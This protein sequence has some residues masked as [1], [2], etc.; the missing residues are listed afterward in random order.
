MK[1]MLINATQPE[2][3]RVAMVDGQFL[4]DL[5]IEVAGRSQRK[6]SIYKAKITRVEQSLEAAFVDYGAERHGFLPFKE[7]AHEYYAD[8]KTEVGEPASVKDVLAEGLELLVQVEKEERGRKGAA[9]TTFPSLAGRYL[10]LMP[11]NPRAGGISRRI[12]GEDRAELRE[13]L[14]VLEVPAGMGLIVRTAGVGKSPEELQWDLDYLLKLWRAI[15]TAVD[16]RTGPFLVYQESNVIIRAIRD[17]FSKDVSE[18]LIDD[19]DVYRQAQDFITQVMPESAGRLRRYEGRVPLFSRFQI[20]SQIESAFSHTVRL[21]SGGSIVIDHTEALV[22][23]DVNSARATKGSDIEE[24]ALNTNL[25]AADEVARQLRLR[26][27]GGLIVI[28][29]IDMTPTRNQREVEN[30]LREALKQDRARIQ[31]RRISRFGLLEMSRQRL[32]PSLGDSSLRTC[33]TCNGRGYVRDPESLALSILRIVEEE[34]M[35]DKTGRI[36]A[37][38]P[39]EV[40]TFLLNEKREGVLDIEKRNGAQIFLVPDP[41]VTLPNYEVERVREE[42]QRNESAREA[43][44]ELTAEVESTPAFATERA[45]PKDEPAVKAAPPPAPAPAPAP[46]PVTSSQPSTETPDKTGL[47]ARIWKK[48]FGNGRKSTPTPTPTPAPAKPRPTSKGS[49][50][51]DVRRDSTRRGRGDGADPRRRGGGP[52]RGENRPGHGPNHG[53]GR[54]QRSERAAPP[55]PAAETTPS[56]PSTP[57]EPSAPV[58]EAPAAAGGEGRSRSGRRGSRRGRR[59]GSRNRGRDSARAAAGGVDATQTPRT[60]TQDGASD[61]GERAETELPATSTGNRTGDA[62]DRAETERPAASTSRTSGDTGERA[63]TERPAAS[64][65]RTSGDTGERAETERPAAS[66]SRT[67]GDTGER[68]ETERPPASAS[69]TSGDTGERA[70]T[71]RPAASASRTSGDTGERAETERPAASASRTSGDTGEHAETERPAASAGRTSGDTGERAET[72]RPPASTSRSTRGPGETRPEPDG[73][74]AETAAGTTPPAA[75]SLSPDAAHDAVRLASD[76][77]PASQKTRPQD[78]GDVSSGSS[79]APSDSSSLPPGGP[80][81]AAGHAVTPPPRSVRTTPSTDAADN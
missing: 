9:L 38:L 26:D 61:V 69:R 54:R 15:E 64:A 60:D 51:H 43:S 50:R 80:S 42:D 46:A 65:S 31:I 39:I 12:E 6:A 81:P 72:E 4:Y 63:E 28:D 49:G 48:L 55:A 20:E 75:P 71:E 36:V 73:G 34:A 24:T 78:T 70:E 37:R 53:D 21:P 79:A 17:Y 52:P 45:A 7:I 56:A 18:I 77:R 35:K 16:E 8:K 40:A 2:E 59:G 13:A 30:R 33:P 67:S 47:V 44:Y 10:V 41:S 11:N 1:R 76:P 57:S 23:I 66:A 3:C 62:D 68:A 29:F 22:S 27:V 5:D 32:R 25:E 74:G 19:E 58:S 14:S